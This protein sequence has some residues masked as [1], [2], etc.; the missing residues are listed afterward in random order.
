SKMM[1]TLVMFLATS[2]ICVHPYKILVYNSKY[3]HSHS[4][5]L[6]SI[7]DL[8]VD[9]GHNVTSLIPVIIDPE[10]SD[11]TFKTTKIH[12]PQS[13]ATAEHVRNMFAASK[14]DLFHAKIFDPI[15]AYQ[16][17]QMF[18]VIFSSQCEAVLETPGL[19]Q[20][21]RAESYDVMFTEHFDMCGTA[22]TE[23]IKPK[24]FIPTSSCSL[25]GQQ[26][27]E[28]GI[29]TA[30]SSNPEPYLSNTKVHSTWD[31]LVNIYANILIRLSFGTIR[32]AIDALFQKKFG[33][34]FPSLLEIS[35]KSA[36]IF[37]NS[38][39]LIDFAAP[40]LA[41]VIPIGGIGAKNPQPL[42]EKWES[43][44][45]KRSKNV[46]IS[47][48]SSAL[49]VNLPMPVKMSILET[50]KSIPQVTFIWKY[51]ENDDF[52]N[53]IASNIP[54]VHLTKWMPQVDLLAHPAVSAFVTHGGMGSTQ[55]AAHSG[56]PGIFVPIFGDQ[57]RNAGMMEQN[58]LGKVLSK[59]DLYDPAKLNAAVREVLE[60]KCYRKSAQRVAQMLRSK[61]FAVADLIVKYTEFAAEFGPSAALR[62]QSHDMNWIEYHNMDIIIAAIAV[63][64][65]LTMTSMKIAQR[66]TIE[67]E[68]D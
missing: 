52:A 5:F 18:S 40:T 3:G 57:P 47:F 53:D 7:A 17:G 66:T 68:K 44:L 45:S 54:N 2:L 36:F 15:A 48:G 67:D 27:E 11:G 22:L 46:L 16:L 13:T 63:L 39:P 9:A 38:E 1:L 29:P 33:T 10:S 56:V 4:N 8:L 61:P 24:A 14:A 42:D 31:R 58:G 6:G 32:P 28:F 19:I 60:N 12:V 23:L 64:M 21:L 20:M 50:A 65:M 37:I 49:S 43:I 41:K 35:S 55:E 59:Y 51:E 25:F 26:F 34:N 30:L 62:P